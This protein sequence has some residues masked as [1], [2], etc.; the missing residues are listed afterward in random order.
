MKRAFGLVAVLVCASPAFSEITGPCPSVSG[1]NFQGAGPHNVGDLSKAPEGLRE[2][3]FYQ[4]NLY[5]ANLS[6]SDLTGARFCWGT[7]QY[8]NFEG[9]TLDGANFF[10]ANVS[11]ASFKSADLIGA[12]FQKAYIGGANFQGANL[13]GATLPTDASHGICSIVYDERTVFPEGFGRFWR[14]ACE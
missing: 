4:A 10:Q 13:T 9:A 7:F 11:Q 8:T 3:D 5:G 2:A 14:M 6:G 12:R 1:A